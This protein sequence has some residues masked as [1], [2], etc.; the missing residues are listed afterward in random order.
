MKNLTKEKNKTVYTVKK[1]AGLV[2]GEVVGDG[3]IKISGASGIKEAK[4]GDITFLANPKYFSLMENTKASAIIVPRE[5]KNR[6]MDRTVIVADNPSIAFAR[7]VEILAPNEVVKPQGISPLAVIGKNVRRG[8]NV[9]IQPFV[10]IEDNVQIGDNAVVYSGVYIGHHT[11]IGKNVIIYPNV[12][13]R[14]Y[15]TIG[16]RVII[17]SGTV[18]GSDGF[19]FATVKGVHHRIPQIGT[20]VI[21]DDVEIGSNVTID[22]ARFDKTLIGR[23]TKIDN[24]VQIAHNVCVG[25]N[26]VIVA[27]TGIS[28]SVQIGSN[29]TLAGQSGVIGHIKIGDNVVVAARSGVTKSIEDNMCVSGFPARSHNEEKRIKASI[30]RLPKMYSKISDLEKKIQKLEGMLSAKDNS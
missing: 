21:E 28:G 12:S 13:V 11:S 7:F 14:E 3:S 10:V 29:V 2:D 27:Q 18:I 24:L 26:S 4:Q 22:R 23:G 16:D 17:H 20:V 5:L 6:P 25:E 19:G 8:K 9:A 1:I 15:T 30:Q